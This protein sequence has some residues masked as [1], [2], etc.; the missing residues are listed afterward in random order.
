MTNFCGYDIAPDMVR[1]SRV[2]MYLHGFANPRIHEYDTLTSEERWDERYDLILANPPFMSPKGGIRPHNRF[3]IKATRSEVLFVDYI[4][5]HLNVTG[6]AGVIVPEGIIF[7]SQNAYKKL[8]TMLADNYLWYVVSLPAGCFNPY[9]GVKTSIL[10]LDKSLARRTDEILFVKVENDGFDL[11]AQRRPIEKNDLPEALKEIQNWRAG[12]KP[13]Q[14]HLAH[15]VSRKR[16]LD[17]TDCGLS[18]DRYRD[19]TIRVS[20]NWPMVRLGDACAINP[21]K[22]EVA[23]LSGALQVSFVPMSDLTEGQP[24]LEAKQTRELREVLKGYT[25]FRDGDVLLA[26]ITPCFENGKTAVARNLRN[27]VGFGSTEFIVLRPDLQRLI[28]NMLYHFIASQVFR[29]KGKAHMTGSAGQQRVAITFVESYQ[30]PLPPVEVQDKIVAE[31]EGFQKII[32]GAK[33]VIANYKLTIRIN[34]AWPIV[35]IG[36]LCTR[37]QY[38]LS[39]ALNTKER[40]YK[41]FR[42]NEIV[43]GTLVDNGQMKCADI[44]ADEFS[45]YRLEKGDILFNRTNSY[46]HVG[47]TGIFLLDG[48]YAF[49]SYLIRLSI[50]TRRAEAHFVNLTMNT[51]DFQQGIKGFASRA[52]GQ[53]NINA[54]NLASYEIPLPPLSVQRQVVDESRASGR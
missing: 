46:E 51:L 54:T 31:L 42:M 21:P 37:I 52:I 16:I 29:R 34:P 24:A 47:R 13:A 4:A 38:G 20:N 11:G 39:S 23:G 18:G 44:S 15:A 6:R 43:N 48:E 45:K 26:K 8:R 53:A 40:G 9:S 25:Y 30:V 14:D 32:E 5:E 35:R 2:N 22:S 28:P 50:D 12:R 33:Q 3:A 41:T 7:Q 19:P 49:A 10:F 1:L 17:S 27:G 36:E